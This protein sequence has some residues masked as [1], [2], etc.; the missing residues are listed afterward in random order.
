MCFIFESPLTNYE[1]RMPISAYFAWMYLRF[2]HGDPSTQAHFA[3]H[4]FFPINYQETMETLSSRMYSS[5]NDTTGLFDYLQNRKKAQ[6]VSA[7]HYSKEA[8]RKKYEIH[9]HLHFL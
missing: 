3:L 9:S 6:Q 1:I 2:I 4:T 5:I 7:L 8:D